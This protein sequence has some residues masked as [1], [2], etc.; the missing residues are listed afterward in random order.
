MPIYKFSGDLLVEAEDLDDA[1]LA[2]AEHFI[3]LSRGSHEDIESI[4]GTDFNVSCVGPSKC[5]L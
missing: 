1:F 3:E 2:L 4:P 5:H